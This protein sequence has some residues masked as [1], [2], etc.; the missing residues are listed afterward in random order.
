MP[1]HDPELPPRVLK[2]TA[3]ACETIKVDWNV[4][5]DLTTQQIDHYTLL[6]T[7]G[8]RANTGSV[9]ANLSLVSTMTHFAAT[10][11]LAATTYGAE[12]RATNPRGSSPWSQRLVVS[13]PSPSHKPSM[14]P[15][16]SITITEDTCDVKIHARLPGQPSPER[17]ADGCSGAESLELQAL[18]AG[19]TEWRT[20]RTKR[21]ETQLRVL[22][23]ELAAAHAYRFRF[24][25]YN[26]FG[27]GQPGESSDAV[28]GGLTP[29]ILMRPP[30]VR[31]TSSASFVV[32]LPATPAHCLE[33]LVW[34]VLVRLAPARWQV[35]G[36]GLQGSAFVAERLRCPPKAAGC[37]FKLQPDVHVFGSSE[38][39]GPSTFVQNVQ[40]PAIG[41]SAVRIELRLKGVE[42]SSLQRNAL[43]G[44]LA[45]TLG[46][47]E[48]PEVVEVQHSS[49]S[50]FLIVELRHWAKEAA[51]EA[52]Q[53]LSNLLAVDHLRNVGGGS[54]LSRIERST[55]VLQ[56]LDSGEWES[57]PPAPRRSVL[58]TMGGMLRAG[59][60]LL[61]CL[62]AVRL[63]RVYRRRRELN[64]AIPLATSEEDADDAERQPAGRSARFL[65][66]DD[67]PA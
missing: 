45:S 35:L 27:E 50:T 6:I 47:R 13:T 20:I 32:Q 23:S 3:D 12:L 19:W 56:Q 34:I 54:V 2:L 16:P 39:D 10:Q 21:S 42:W 66:D 7:Q 62:A 31:A 58:V 33:S 28:I 55:G 61:C 25:A 30:V 15:A 57:L 36:T 43:T 26:R 64:G 51:Q 18:R 53:E 9:I 60:F 48:E 67:F 5:I 49:G 22:D 38:A 40:L 4:P 52:A 1:L 65:S 11:L 17:R 37:E 29:A 8:P 14:L 41:P 24:Q 59:A 44:A 63:M 46:L